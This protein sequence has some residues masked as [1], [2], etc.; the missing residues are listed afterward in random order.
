M[1]ENKKQ[2]GSTCSDCGHL[3]A[4]C[5]RCKKYHCPLPVNIYLEFLRSIQC[6]E[7]WRCEDEGKSKT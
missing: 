7:D 2:S 5:G 6:V 1:M 3:D 4:K